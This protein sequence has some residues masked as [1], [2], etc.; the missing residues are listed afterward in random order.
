[1]YN[2]GK[3][4]A[5][6]NSHLSGG[7]HIQSQFSSWAADLNTAIGYGRTFPTSQ[8]AV[9]DATRTEAH[10]KVHHTPDLH[11][12]SLPVYSYPHEYLAYGPIRG[13]AFRCM[14]VKEMTTIGFPDIFDPSNRDYWATVSKK[15]MPSTPQN[16]M[17]TAK[18]TGLRFQNHGGSGP[19]VVV[20]LTAAIMGILYNRRGE[21]SCNQRVTSMAAKI[22]AVQLKAIGYRRHGC[23]E[24]QLTNPKTLTEG[25]LALK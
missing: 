2:I 21:T 1:M 6:I 16:A 23:A 18:K 17:I 13:D 12:V 3:I 10:V 15:S 5:M 8:I 19:D 11:Y 20:A 25:S 4:R 24:A 7:R 14:P 22:L 9:F